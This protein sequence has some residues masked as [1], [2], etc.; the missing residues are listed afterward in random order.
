ML[1]HH[2]HYSN[3]WCGTK[4]KKV[5]IPTEAVLSQPFKTM[6][7]RTVT[8][9]RDLISNN[10]YKHLSGNLSFTVSHH[11]S[12]KGE[13]NKPPPLATGSQTWM[14]LACF[15]QGGR[16]TQVGAAGGGTK[17]RNSVKGDAESCI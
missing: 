15:Q 2:P 7:L 3:Q 9:F 5:V 13:E 10:A 6:L 14:T 17:E 12:E 4:Q 11:Q 16:S 8:F 1:P